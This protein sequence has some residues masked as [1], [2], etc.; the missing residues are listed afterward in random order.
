LYVA[1]ADY[2]RPDNYNMG[3]IH[4]FITLDTPHGGSSFANLVIALH[5]QKPTAIEAS[6]HKLVGADAFVTNG[7]V[8]DLAENSQVLAM[9]TPTSI[10]SQVITATGGPAGTPTGG[11]FFGGKFGN[12]D[13]EGELTNCEKKSPPIIGTCV[14]YTYD[15]T[16]VN[17]FRFRQANDAIV[18]LC[19]QQGGMNGTSC[20]AGGSAGI[21]FSSLLHFGASKYCITVHGVCNTKDVPTQVFKLLDGPKSGFSSSLPG[22]SSAGTG[23]A[24]TVPGIGTVADAKNF[25]SQC[26]NG[27]PPPMK[28]NVQ[29]AAQSS[30]KSTAAAGDSRIKVDTPIQ[31]QVFKPGDTVSATISIDPSLKASYVSLAVYGLLGVEGTG[32]NGSSY[33]ATFTIPTGTTGPLQLV[34]QITDTSGNT[35]LGLTT[36]IAV[37]PATAPISLTI[38]QPN[39]VLTSIGDTDRIYITGNYPGSVTLDLTSSASGTTYKSSNAAVV[40]VDTEGNVKATGFGTAVVTI[41]NMG[42]QAFE[43]FTVEDPNHPLAPQDVTSAVN[44]IGAGFR[45]D[46]NTGFFDQMVMWT[47]KSGIPV[48]GP[49]YFVV[50]GLPAGVALIGAGITKNITPAGTPYFTLTLPDGITLQPG[51]S[52]SQVLQFLNPDRT[53]IAYTPKIFRTSVSP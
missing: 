32:Y 20:P 39:D 41:S 23:S 33:Q 13:F 24:V 26:V 52:I 3:D 50:T 34:P 37:R 21:N 27:S 17:A 2:M 28:T 51:D 1:S 25:T 4:R 46:R 5:T 47:N 22:I 15:Q 36:T 19:S 18:A 8:C 11:P 31:G 38:S 12:G 14:Q 9:L 44:T 43:T 45:V 29:L 35:I 10:D 40:V 53:R 7:A 49:L 48:V 6:V 30:V 16:T 42:V